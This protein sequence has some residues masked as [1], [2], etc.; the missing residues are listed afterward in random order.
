M[1]PDGGKYGSGGRDVR[2]VESVFVEAK[3]KRLLRSRRRIVAVS[4]T[5]TS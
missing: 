5:L 1:F 4:E 3:R 2:G